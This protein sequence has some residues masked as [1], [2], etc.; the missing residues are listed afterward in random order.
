MKSKCVDEGGS[1]PKWAKLGYCYSSQYKNYMKLKCKKSCKICWIYLCRRIVHFSKPGRFLLGLSKRIGNTVLGFWHN[2]NGRRLVPLHR[3]THRQ[4]FLCFCF[5]QIKKLQLSAIQPEFPRLRY[6]L[7]FCQNVWQAS[8][9][10]A[11]QPWTQWGWRTGHCCCYSPAASS[12]TRNLWLEDKEWWGVFCILGNLEL[13]MNFRP[14]YFGC[15]VVAFPD[16][17]TWGRSFGEAR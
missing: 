12:R 16:Q 1:C 4:L 7:N 8:H 6:V 2:W 9:P 15:L 11:R 10:L 14:V 3:S 13:R 17:T 5:Q